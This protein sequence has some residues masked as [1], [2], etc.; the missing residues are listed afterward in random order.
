VN[1]EREKNVIK[2]L[3]MLLHLINLR[4]AF[5]QFAFL[6]RRLIWETFSFLPQVDEM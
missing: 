5:S 6:I 4:L 3:E 1:N 2:I